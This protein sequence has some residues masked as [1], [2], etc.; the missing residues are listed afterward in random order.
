MRRNVLSTEAVFMLVTAWAIGVPI[1]ILGMLLDWSSDALGLIE[2]SIGLI[3]LFVARPL[4][5]WFAPRIGISPPRPMTRRQ[6]PDRL[7]GSSRAEFP[8]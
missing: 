6:K 7:S 2:I 1:F 3:V 8:R 4:Q 5:A